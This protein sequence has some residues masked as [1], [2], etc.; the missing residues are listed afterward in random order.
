MS[1][2]ILI[3]CIAVSVSH[4]ST[5]NF[6][7]IWQDKE[8]KQVMPPESI[9]TSASFVINQQISMGYSTDNFALVCENHFYCRRISLRKAQK[10]LITDV[11]EE[12]IVLINVLLEQT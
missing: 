6:N 7:D 10:V 11:K 2:A 9:D 5:L 8:D 4:N 12:K 1:I 3:E